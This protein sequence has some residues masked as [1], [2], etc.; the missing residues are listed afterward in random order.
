MLRASLGQKVG[1]QWPTWPQAF[2][3]NATPAGDPQAAARSPCLQRGCAGDKA[4]FIPDKSRL[5]QVSRSAFA[6]PALPPTLRG[7]LA[8]YFAAP[9]GRSWGAATHAE[10]GSGVTGHQRGWA[11]GLLPRLRALQLRPACG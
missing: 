10:A 2:R 8:S 11:S 3:T 7:R 4:S 9:G 5:F 6:H 1:V